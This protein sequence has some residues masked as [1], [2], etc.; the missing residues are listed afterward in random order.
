MGIAMKADIL[1]KLV[2]GGQ[3]GAD[4]AAL[5]WAISRGVP[6]GGWCPKDRK[7]EDGPIPVH[8]DIQETNSTDYPTRTERNVLDSDGTVIISLEAALGSRGSA[9]TQRL[10]E[11]HRKPWIHIHSGEL[12][13]GE[14]LRGFVAMHRIQTFNVAGPRASSEPRIAQFVRSVLDGAFPAA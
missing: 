9:L 7:A 5:D 4:R 14:T 11:K 6:H 2:S 13:P 3:T 12:G 1:L 8:Y 10:A